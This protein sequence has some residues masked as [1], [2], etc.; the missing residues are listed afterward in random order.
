[1]SEA[2]KTILEKL[3]EAT[4]NIEHNPNDAEAYAVRAAIYDEMGDFEASLSD[5]GYAIKLAKD[6]PRYWIYRA[7]VYYHMQRFDAA[8]VD[9][10]LAIAQDNSKA[11]QYEL[12]GMIHNEMQ[13]AEAAI[14]DF[15]LAININPNFVSY[16]IRAHIYENSGQ[17]DLAKADFEKALELNPNDISTL[18]ALLR[19]REK[20]EIVKLE[21]KIELE[22]CWSL[23]AKK[24]RKSS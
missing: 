9:V 7:M 4:A 1:M 12:R 10:D 21:P 15:S 5:L 23:F 20:P 2:S 14:N 17:F 8:L 24:K 11:E 3:D 6:K 18:E 19:F 13:K 16:S 22:G